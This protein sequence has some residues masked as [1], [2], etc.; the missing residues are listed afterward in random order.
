M[1]RSDFQ[2]LTRVRVAE[3]RD[4][5]ATNRWDG[6]YYI[7]GYAIE[8]ALKACIAKKTRA[9]DFPD[10]KTVADSYTHDL[11]AL[12]K[13]AGLDQ[14]LQIEMQADAA[15]GVN[16]GTAKDWSE[17]SRYERWT[18]PEARSLFTAIT[19][20]QHGVLRWLRRHW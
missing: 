14:Q 18:E 19:N 20:Q 9:N 3:A 15:F 11:S 12:I 4:L 2:R 6:A 16:W 13:V 7:A 17:Q 8:C 5:L 10:K 1:N